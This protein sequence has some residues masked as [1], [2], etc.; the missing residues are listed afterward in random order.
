MRK[1]L[2]AAL[3]PCAL[4][5]LALMPGQVVA[6]PSFSTTI[7]RDTCV[8]GAGKYHFGQ[9]VLR[10]RLIEYGKSGANKF[11]FVAQ[12]WH[13]P[14]HGSKWSKEYQWPTYETTFPNNTSSYYNSRQFAYAPDHNAYHKIVVRVRAWHNDTVLYSKLIQGETC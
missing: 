6:A 14:I 12:V 13:L 5:L 1:R 4:L 10:V 2:A 3:L 8:A 11:T 9:G 7:E